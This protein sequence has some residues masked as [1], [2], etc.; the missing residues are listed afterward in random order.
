M[1]LPNI[2][3]LVPACVLAAVFLSAAFPC[4]AQD[5]DTKKAAK[6][7]FRVTRFDPEDRQSP[8][9]RAGSGGKQLEIEVPLTF[10]AGPF[11]APLRDGTTLDLWQGAAE[12]PVIS[13]EI[14]PAEREHLLLV[15][16][17]QDETFRVLKV[18]APPGR[19]KGG[20][21]FMI[22]A[23]PN[24]MAIKLGN[25]EPLMIPASKSGVLAGPPGSDIVSLPVLI[26]L[27]QDDE[28]KLASTEQWP[29]DPRFRKFLVAYMSPRTRQ[30]VFH[31]VTERM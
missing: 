7:E 21:R 31:S 12:K 15:F 19:I 10:I 23:T 24:E 6:I 2:H 30:L 27:K 22:N 26:S 28:W 16:F 4:H 1:S 14:T 17:Q 9:F 11:E 8:V 18:H 5:T 3:P 25:S 13:L 20:D 29:C